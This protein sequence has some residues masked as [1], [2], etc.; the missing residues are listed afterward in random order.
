MNG[1]VSGARAASAKNRRLQAERRDVAR[2]APGE[3]RLRQGARLRQQQPQRLDDLAVDVRELVE[4]LVKDIVE[5]DLVPGGSLTAGVT[6]RAVQRHAAVA[7][8]GRERFVGRG[9]HAG[10]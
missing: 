9:R 3:K 1:C 4:R 2:A 7:A 8:H 6:E 5:A 10:E